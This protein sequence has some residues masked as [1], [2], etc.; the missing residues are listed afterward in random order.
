MLVDGVRT[1]TQDEQKPTEMNNF[2]AEFC[3][4]KHS[5]VSNLCIS[6]LIEMAQIL[7]LVYMNEMQQNKAQ[8]TMELT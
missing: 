1:M 8:S 4:T 6:F 5:D 7:A 3:M 2:I